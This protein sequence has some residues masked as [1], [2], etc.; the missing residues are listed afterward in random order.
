MPVAA[1]LSRKLYETLGDE[2]AEAMVSWMD[3]VEHNRAEL[4]EMNDLAFARIDARFGEMDARIDGR[5]SEMDARID[6]R[7]AEMD[8][9]IDGRF[10]EMDARID[11][12]FGEMEARFDAKLDREIGQ[13]R[14]EMAAGFGRVESRIEQRFADLMKWSLTFWLGSVIALI[15]ALAILR[16][17]GR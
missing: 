11:G 14:Q 12:R 15:G 4:R 7:F 16:Q 17:F 6:G 3:S 9:R 2:A 1:K 13:L 8:A 10:G 5:F